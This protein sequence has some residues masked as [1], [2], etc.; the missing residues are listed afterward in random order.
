MYVFF[1]NENVF[2]RGGGS[3][4]LGVV[5][6]ASFLLGAAGGVVLSEQLGWGMYLVAASCGIL[7]IKVV[8]AAWSILA[9][10]GHLK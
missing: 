2:R 1:Q 8:L 3:L 10:V 7:L 5:F 4:F 6:S 9:G